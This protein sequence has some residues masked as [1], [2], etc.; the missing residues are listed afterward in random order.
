[1]S[2]SLKGSVWPKEGLGA[3]I[4]GEEEEELPEAGDEEGTATGGAGPAK[5][6]HLDKV[7][8]KAEEVE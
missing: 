7:R 5:G 4:D 3:A 2:G 6:G 8:S 1:M